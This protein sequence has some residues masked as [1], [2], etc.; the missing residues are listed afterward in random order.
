M[1]LQELSSWLERELIEHPEWKNLAIVSI[2]NI[3]LPKELKIV[4]HVDEG[5]ASIEQVSGYQEL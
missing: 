2:D 1:S 3:W 5:H 4:A